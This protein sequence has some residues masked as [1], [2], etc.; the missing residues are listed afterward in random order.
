M[1]QLTMLLFIGIWGCFLG[2]EGGETPTPTIIRDITPPTIV[3][4]NVQGG[5]IPVNT[6]IVLV[7][8]ERVTL[9]SARQGITVRASIDAERVKGVITLQNKGREVKF[10]PVELMTSGAYVLT[11]LGVEDAQGN[12]SMPASVFFAAIEVDTTQPTADVIPP[13][14]ASSIP[15]EGQSVKTT[16]SLV[17]RFDEEVDA[18]SAQMGIVV[19]GVEG[20][21]EVT[22]AVA[23]FKPQKPMTAGKHTLTIVGVRDLAGNGLESSLIIS[24]EVIAPPPAEIEPPIT[25]RPLRG[26]ILFR[27]DFE[28]NSNVAVPNKGVNRVD[29]WKP[30][31]P[32][33]EW[34]ITDFTGSGKGLVQI[35]EGCG[36]SGNTPLPGNISFTDGIIQLDMSW[37]D[38]DS[39][40]VI[41]RRT[42]KDKGYLVVFGYNETPAVIVAKLDDG[43]AD[44]GNCLDQVG[45]ENNDANTLA[46]VPH[47]LGQ[48][49]PQ[50]NNTVFVGRIE[51]IGNTI[52]VWFLPRKDVKDV[53]A[54]SKAL[55]KPLVEVKDNT[56]K[57]GS[58]GIW[59]E[60]QGNSK[61]DNVLVTGGG[62]F[63]VDAS[64]KL[65]T[66][67][68]DVKSA[69]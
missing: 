59:H 38:D 16:D 34:A 30:E 23:I 65:A 44:V 14:V 35:T 11:A 4:T 69:Y 33:T 58:V 51:A 64:D 67:W 47:G 40:G 39:W 29:N 54:D 5:P 15:A 13:R 50:D 6:P 7:F 42:D 55:G 66:S 68:G 46:Q 12:I 27:A 3:G 37:G 48:G 36:A 56:H 24:F 2:C 45:C 43:C 31:N 10:T 8:N 60:S 19:S 41:F 20:K 21:V 62:G 32:Q 53:F 25:G 1:K 63:A 57:S 9:A 52:R 49:L 61:I 18:D 22:G 26:G 28:P 17:V